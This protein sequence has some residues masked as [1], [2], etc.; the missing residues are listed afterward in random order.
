MQG[1]SQEWFDG[2]IA[3]KISARDKLFRKFKETKLQ[4][5]SDLWREA[6]YNVDILIKS[7]KRN[8]YENRIK[9]NT[10]KPKEL[11]KT[12]KSLGMG[13]NI[14]NTVNYCLKDKE[15]ISFDTE[16]KMKIFRNF[17]TGLAD[18]LIMKLPCPSNKFRINSVL[19]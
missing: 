9:E 19:S 3:E 16:S 15:T 11:W 5:D 6:K 18:S 17:F 14:D 13:N 2:E 12:L 10:A 4:V 8:F 7:K 1:S